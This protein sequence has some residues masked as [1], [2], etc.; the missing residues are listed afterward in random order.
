[1]DPYP[2]A[3]SL[4]AIEALAILRGASVGGKKSEAF[5]VGFIRK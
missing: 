5:E 1:M 4:E 3:R 2:N